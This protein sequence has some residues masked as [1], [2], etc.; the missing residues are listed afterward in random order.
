MKKIKICILSLVIAI[1][2]CSQAYASWL[3]L[4]QDYTVSVAKTACSIKAEPKAK[5]DVIGKMPVGSQCT[6]LDKSGNWYLIEDNGKQGYVRTKY[7]VDCESV[8]D[9]LRSHKRFCTYSLTVSDE[10]VPCYSDKACTQ[11]LGE[12]N[13]Q[14]IEAVTFSYEWIKA[15]RLHKIDTAY[16]TDFEPDW[17]TRPFYIKANYELQPIF[18]RATWY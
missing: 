12:L 13:S 5:S 4:K 11:Y 9:Y 8:Y 10:T 15:H 6:I 2:M 3:P 16:I 18:K 1:L 14:D 7:I 17:Y